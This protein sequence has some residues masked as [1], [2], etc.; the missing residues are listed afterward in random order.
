MPVFRPPVNRDTVTITNASPPKVEPSTQPQAHIGQG[1]PST[2]T[3]VLF[4]GTVADYASA[5]T[6]A[7]IDTLGQGN[8]YVMARVAI[9]HYGVQAIGQTIVAKWD[10]ASQGTF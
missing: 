10:S 4:P 8:F 1:V 2:D 3:H 9:D 5:P 6:N 7:A